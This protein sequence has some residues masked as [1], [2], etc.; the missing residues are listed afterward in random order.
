MIEVSTYDSTDEADVWRVRQAIRNIG[1]T[2]ALTYLAETR[3]GS[4]PP[5]PRPRMRTRS[6]FD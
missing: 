3:P 5:Q 6:L 1:I 4:P 2:A